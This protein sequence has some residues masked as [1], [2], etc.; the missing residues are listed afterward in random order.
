MLKAR[1]DAEHHQRATQVRPWDYIFLRTC[2]IASSEGTQNQ[3]STGTIFAKLEAFVTVPSYRYWA[4]Q[5]RHCVYGVSRG[6]INFSSRRFAKDSPSFEF[7]VPVKY[8]EGKHYKR[9]ENRESIP[10]GIIF[11][12]DLSNDAADLSSSS[13]I[14]KRKTYIIVSASIVVRLASGEIRVAH[15]ELSTLCKGLFDFIKANETEAGSVSLDVSA[16]L[17]SQVILYG[18]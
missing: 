9:S 12:S 13:A 16:S 8:W 1:D 17:K 14:V 10:I 2:L 7:P 18:L 5:V 6:S 4:L 15:E 3:K 11:R